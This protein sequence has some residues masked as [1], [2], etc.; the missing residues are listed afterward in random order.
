MG[1]RPFGWKPAGTTKAGKPPSS[2]DT[3]AVVILEG[4]EITRIDL[5]T[6]GVVPGLTDAEFQAMAED[7]KANCI[8]SKALKAVPMT[9]QATLATG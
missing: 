7:A 8:V 6:R 4:L 2:I 9:L 1:Q 3:K 5:T